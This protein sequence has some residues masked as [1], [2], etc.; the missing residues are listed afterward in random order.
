[1]ARLFTFGCS[2]TQWPW[3]TWADIIAYDLDIEFQ[4]WGIPGIGNVGIHSRMIECDIRNSFTDEDILMVVWSSWTR[5]DRSDIKKSTFGLGWTA[6]GDVF[7]S[8]DKNFIDNHWSLENDLVKNSVAMI[9]TSKMFEK[10]LKFQGHIIEPMILDYYNDQINF[11]EREKTIAKFYEPY[12][13]NQGVFQENRK[14]SCRYTKTNDSHPDILS[15]MDYVQEFICPVLNRTLSN[16]TIEHFT[17]MHNELLHYTENVMDTS[18]GIDYRNK[19]HTVLAS[20]GWLAAKYE[21]F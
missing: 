7:N 14:H 20:Y 21:G 15:H 19:I 13:I 10:N 18:D 1:M 12:I 5:E 6:L 9:S 8:Y 2:F 16:R 11:N 3:P 17:R 4:N